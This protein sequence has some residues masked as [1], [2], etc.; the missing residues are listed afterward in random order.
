[1]RCTA[2][3]SPARRACLPSRNARRRPRSAAS[4][5]VVQKGKNRAVDSYS[6]FGD[7][8]GGRMEKTELEDVLR[9]R[10]IVEV[11]AAGLATDYCVAFTCQDA[12][13]AGFRTFMVEDAS[14]GIAKESIE[15]ARQRLEELGVSLVTSTEL[16]KKAAWF[17]NEVPSLEAVWQEMR[18]SKARA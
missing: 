2:R 7:A 8:S 14:R 11:F 15:E 16:P 4:D 13:K 17:E 12:A 9:S 18:G 5:V 10:G 3:A 1:M 6:G